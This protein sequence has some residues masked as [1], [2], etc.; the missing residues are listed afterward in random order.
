M[1]AVLSCN[2]DMRL[3]FVL[4]KSR[5]S[6]LMHSAALLQAE[7]WETVCVLLLWLSQLV[8]LPFDLALLDSSLTA[9]EDARS[10]TPQRDKGCRPNCGC[11]E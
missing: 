4:M 1:K 11:G 3:H 10:I 5:T 6:S 8:T 7:K 2:K 9:A